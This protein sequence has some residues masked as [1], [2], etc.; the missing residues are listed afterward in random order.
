M[1][2]QQ[3]SEQTFKPKIS[4][5]SQKIWW[6]RVVSTHLAQEQQRKTATPH[7]ELNINLNKLVGMQ[8]SE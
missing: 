5:A 1:E 6:R 7:D 3:A 8:P 2:K 4:Q